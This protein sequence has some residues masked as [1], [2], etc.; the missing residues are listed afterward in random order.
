MAASTKAVSAI[1]RAVWFSELGAAIDEAQRL[2]WQLGVG[3][4][5]ADAVELYVRLEIVRAEVEALRGRRVP[6][7]EGATGP[8]RL[9]E[10]E[11]PAQPAER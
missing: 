6:G 2:A 9:F 1:A 11:Q 5:C 10:P 7:F 8:G 4:G 3:E